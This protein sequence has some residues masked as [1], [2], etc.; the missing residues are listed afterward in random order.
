MPLSLDCDAI[1]ASNE[2]S[3]CS[4]K[5]AKITVNTLI[6]GSQATS[7]SLCAASSAG[8][9]SWLVEGYTVQYHHSLGQVAAD[10]PLSVDSTSFK[11]RST[12]GNDTFQCTSSDGKNLQKG[13]SCTLASGSKSPVDGSASFRFDTNSQLLLVNQ[14]W[15]CSD[16]A[17]QK[18]FVVPQET[19]G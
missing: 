10:R 16:P 7:P 14:T 15:A 6:E 12:A 8:R 2:P 13:L 4:T 3:R 9:P 18:S 5:A 19:Y 11:L 1:G 17:S